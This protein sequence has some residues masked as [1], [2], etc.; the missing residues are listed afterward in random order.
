MEPTETAAPLGAEIGVMLPPADTGSAPSSPLQVPPLLRDAAGWVWRLLVLAV[1][2]YALVQ[3]FDKLYLLVLPILG[4]IFIAALLRP[5]VQTFRNRGF[6]RAVATWTTLLLGFAAM[7]S[8][9]F[10]VSYRIS[11]ESAILRTSAT[12]LVNNLRNVAVRDLH[13]APASVD[14]LQTRLVHYINT[15]HSTVVH[16]VVSTTLVVAEALTGA[17]LGFFIC[18][19]L[20][21]DGDRIWDWLVG[22]FPRPHRSRIH[23]AGEEAWGRISGWVRGTFLIALFHS[24]VVAITLTALGAPL[25]APL[26]LIVFLGSFIPIIGSI[27]FGGL[28]ALVTLVDAGVGSALILVGVLVL[29]SQVEAHLLQPFLVGRYVRLHPLAVVIVIAGG[30]FLEGVPGAIIALPLTSAM[31]A[32]AVSLRDTAARSR[33][34]VPDTS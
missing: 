27:I 12:R 31:F 9:V 10:F 15:H 8:A 28:A 16:G 6:P 11:S 19:F 26:A 5:I 23:E 32:A 30:G 13:V 33:L 17:I 21:Y 18:F 20:L 2:A 1:G 14:N 24:T 25:V 3:L 4:A 7:G 34:E 22:L 29:D